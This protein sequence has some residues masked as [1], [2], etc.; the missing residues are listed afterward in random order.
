MDQDQSPLS[1]SD[2]VLVSG[3]SSSVG[4]RLV[5]RLRAEGVRVTALSRQPMAGERGWIAM[6]LEELAA[7]PDLA[8]QLKPTPTLVHLA[9]IWLLP[10]TI[11]VLGRLGLARLVAFSSTSRFTKLQARDA[12]DR[13]LASKL[14]RAEDDTKR[15][16]ADHGVAWTL[17]RPTL[18]YDG[19][20]SGGLGQLVRMARTLGVV[21][22][23]GPAR[24]L[25]QPVHADDLAAAC[26]GVLHTHATI[27]KAYDLGGGQELPYTEMARA[28]VRAA[29]CEPR[30][31]HLPT[32]L[33]RGLLRVLGLLPA[34]AAL[35]PGVADRMNQDLCFDTTPARRDFGY[36]PGPFDP[37][38]ARESPGP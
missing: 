10:A 21:P 30:L 35:T 26:V 8:A 20:A 32:P 4:Q 22:V 31:L 37:A 34:F 33:L 17:L 19:V 27:G 38:A 25:R 24:G 18:I 3:A 14:Q 15:A 28:A 11:P 1:R 13:R 7:A 12:A 23:A 6:D 2:P 9:P 5:P 36:A 29:G 16:C